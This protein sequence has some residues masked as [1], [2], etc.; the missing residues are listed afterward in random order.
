MDILKI[1]ESTTKSSDKDAP[2][3]DVF[4]VRY[5]DP[6]KKFRSQIESMERID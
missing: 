2:S 5:K 3:T 4:N 1:S 6:E